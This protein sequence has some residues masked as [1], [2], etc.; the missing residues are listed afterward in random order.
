MIDKEE[1]ES[2]ILE[3]IERTLLVLPDTVGSLLVDHIAMSKITNQ[4]YKD[5]PEFKDHKQ[6]VASVLEA[7]DGKN[8]LLDYKD[9]LKKAVPEIKERI[10]TL[11]NLNMETVSSNPNRTYKPLPTT[12]VEEQHGKL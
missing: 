6:A 2:I 4:F 8:P 5:H 3:A 9:K 7:V 1:R 12:K 10:M 11:E